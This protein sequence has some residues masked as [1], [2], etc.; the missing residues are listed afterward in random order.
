MPK[1]QFLRRSHISAN[2]Q[3]LNGLLSQLSPA[4]MAPE[5]PSKTKKSRV[6]PTAVADFTIL[7]LALPALPGLPEQYQDAKHYL[8]IKPHEPSIPS[9]D[10]ERSL[11]LANVPIDASE[12]NLRTLFREQ[13]RGA[14]VERVAFDASIPAEPMHKRWKADGP[15]Q[16]QDSDE[17]RGKKRKRS[18]SEAES[19]VAEGVVEDEDSALPRLWST[20]LRK[21]GSGAVVVFVDK[22]SARGALK[23]VQRAIKEGRRISWKGGEGLGVERK[24][25]NFSPPPTPH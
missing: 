2:I 5:T 21:S 8:Y 6:T 20:E 25:Y 24:F 10:D 1:K 13:L 9:A 3:L 12:A 16:T 14:M 17:K 19:L 15:K 23:E 18:L 11:F 7:P 22:K 4:A